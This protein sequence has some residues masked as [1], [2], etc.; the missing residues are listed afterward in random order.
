MHFLIIGFSPIW[1]QDISGRK[2]SFVHQ[3]WGTIMGVFRR[4]KTSDWMS[5]ID[6]GDQG[7]LS[8][9]HAHT[10][11][12][13]LVSRLSTLHKLTST[14]DCF[15]LC[16]TLHSCGYECC[17]VLWVFLLVYN[18][19]AVFFYQQNIGH[20]CLLVKITAAVL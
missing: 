5:S 7:Y 17:K 9:Q 10:I 18:L 19:A 12:P 8:N 4:Q 6:L 13:W 15:I 3:E 2:G 11:Q 16:M 1:T 20:K 14:N